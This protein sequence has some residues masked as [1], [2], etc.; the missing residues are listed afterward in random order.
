MKR[1]ELSLD[2][3]EM[4][5]LGYRAVDL[6]VEHFT[7]LPGKPVTRRSRR[8]AMEE[9]FREPLPEAGAPPLEVL[10]R[11][12]REVFEHIMHLDHPRFFAFVPSPNNFVSVVA[13]ALA[14]GFNVFAGTWL[15][16]SAPAQVELVTLDWLRD[17]FGLPETAGGLFTSGGSAA[18][19]TA[20]AL[21]RH[22]ILEER[23]EGA[24]VYGSDQTHSSLERGLRI[25]GFGPRA[26]RRLPSDG[27]FRLDPAQLRSAIAADRAAGSRPFCV[28]ANAGTTNT[29]A[30]DPLPALVELC[31][32]E[33][34]WLHADAAYGGA[35]IFC[36]RGRSRLEGIGGVDS[37]S[38][39]PHKW[40]CQPYE[41][42]G[43]LVREAGRLKQAFHVLPEYLKDAAGPPEEVNFCDRGLQLTRSFR[44]LKLWMSLQVFGRRGFEAAVRRG[45][46]LA[47]LAEAAVLEMEDWEVVTGAQMGV[48]TFRCAPP[49]RTPGQVDALQRALVEAALEEGFSMIV[50]TELRGRPVLRLC[51]INP[52][53]T[54]EDLRQALRRLDRHRRRLVEAGEGAGKG[55][56]DADPEERPAGGGAG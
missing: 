35:A 47:E 56:A 50:S 3:E 48:I 52:R 15:E 12:R 42:G 1:R 30:V 18:N 10:E 29:G 46:E 26:F 32:R 38:L 43:L 37:L 5:E 9:L 2:A 34:L 33:G 28:I 13:D 53:T 55:P 40:L 14:A 25:L 39:D 6:L 41:I 16:A 49:E 20:L 19:L 7:S 4:R 8:E 54:A 45:F 21:A 51:P 31:R 23:M 11:V 22:V 44:A 17:L 36:R 27:E 24:V